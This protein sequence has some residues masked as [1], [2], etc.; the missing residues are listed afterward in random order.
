MNPKHLFVGT[1]SDNMQ[2]AYK[3]GR[4]PPPTPR[5]GEAHYKATVTVEIVNLLRS[6]PRDAAK[7]EAKRLGLRRQHAESIIRGQSWR[8]CNPPHP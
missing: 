6:M 8:H 7:A 3:K 5:R 4:L 2:D 1:E